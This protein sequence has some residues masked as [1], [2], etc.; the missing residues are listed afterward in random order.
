MP[1]AE[2]IQKQKMMLRTM[3]TPGLLAKW[4]YLKTSAPSKNAA[5]ALARKTEKELIKRGDLIADDEETT[6]SD[7][8]D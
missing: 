4:H 5:H 3:S 8:P 1:G 7:A 2:V 6:L